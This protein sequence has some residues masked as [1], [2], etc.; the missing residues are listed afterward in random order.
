MWV[1]LR[2]LKGLILLVAFD[3]ILDDKSLEQ[4]IAVNNSLFI[5][6]HITQLHGWDAC[7]WQLPSL[8]EKQVVFI[9]DTSVPLI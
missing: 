7:P 6:W 2:I 8:K 3:I 5:V 4:T 1:M 9:L